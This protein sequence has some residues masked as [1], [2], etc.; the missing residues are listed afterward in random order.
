MVS[1]EALSK[2]DGHQHDWPNLTIHLAGAC[3]EQF[4]GRSVL[5]DGP[6]AV[7]HPA[8]SGHADDV[9]ESGLETAGLIF[10]PA[11]LGSFGG[12][13]LFHRPH[14]WRGGRAALA[15]RQLVGAWRTPSTSAATLR[16]FT[17]A[18]FQ[19]A[20]GEQAPEPQWLPKVSAML[21][22][23]GSRS[24]DLIAQTLGLHPAWLARR[25]REAVGEGLRDTLRR[26]RVEDALRAI[27]MSGAPLAEIAAGAGFC[28]QPH[29]NRCFHLVLGRTPND[30]RSSGNLN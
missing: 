24:T 1:H 21:A 16:R 15:A 19:V 25:Y 26:K 29:M 14:V 13:D 3:I 12:E 17:E 23:E 2:L 6:G 7:F 4:D 30:Y 20:A 9:F 11:W 5:I 10:D 8:R 18:F 22:D 27:R 28:D